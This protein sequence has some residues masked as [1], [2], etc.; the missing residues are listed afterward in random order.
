[1][2]RDWA[3]IE[4]D[5]TQLYAKRSRV[6]VY[7]KKEKEKRERESRVVEKPD[8]HEIVQFRMW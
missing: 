3:I 7:P 5:K 6:V 8:A 4:T 2:G 1:L